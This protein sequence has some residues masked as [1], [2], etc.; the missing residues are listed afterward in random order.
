M[1]QGTSPFVFLVSS[2]RDGKVYERRGV[3]R[4]KEKREEEGGER[5]DVRG[6][7]GDEEQGVI[8]REKEIEE[9]MVMLI[10]K[11]KQGEKNKTLREE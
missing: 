4:G 8:G 7:E 5:G 2:L 1:Y 9:K 11:R 10:K 3:E 6:D